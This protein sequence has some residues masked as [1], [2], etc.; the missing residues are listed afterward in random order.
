MK[1]SHYFQKNV[2]YFN[3]SYIQEYVNQLEI[4][5]SQFKSKQVKQDLINLDIEDFLLKYDL[6]MN[7]KG[8]NNNRGLFTQYLQPYIIGNSDVERKVRSTVSSRSTSY[9]YVNVL[10]DRYVKEGSTTVDEIWDKL[11]QDNNDLVDELSDAQI[12]DKLSTTLNLHK[13]FNVTKKLNCYL[14]RELTSVTNLVKKYHKGNINKW[15]SFDV[16]YAK[17]KDIH[18]K[19]NSLN[20][21]NNELNKL[22]DNSELLLVSLKT[23]SRDALGSKS[24]NTYKKPINQDIVYNFKKLKTQYKVNIYTTSSNDTLT[25]CVDDIYD[26]ASRRWL[27]VFEDALPLLVYKDVI[28]DVILHCFKV[29][30]PNFVIANNNHAEFVDLSSYFTI[31]EILCVIESN[32]IWIN[33]T[34]GANKYCI[35]IREKGGYPYGILYNG[36]HT[37]RNGNKIDIK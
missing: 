8:R 9:D 27:Q 18:I 26:N 12:K 19:A 3:Q 30:S 35:K 28:D 13:K 32:D 37:I 34:K 10:I 29:F 24:F 25:K 1:W 15:C 14:A 7:L 36:Y 4:N 23:T 17:Q 16:Y 11:K 21:I 5:G 6:P 31:D 20:E 2:K 22:T 33:I